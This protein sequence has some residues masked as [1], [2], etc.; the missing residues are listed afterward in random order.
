MFVGIGREGDALPD[1]GR[2]FRRLL[3]TGRAALGTDHWDRSSGWWCIL[4]SDPRTCLG[5][6]SAHTRVSCTAN[7]TI[8]VT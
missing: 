7:A 2:V 6:P 3:V 8:G 5:A 1:T 4:S